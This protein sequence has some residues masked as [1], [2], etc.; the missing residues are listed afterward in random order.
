MK[1]SSLSRLL[2]IVLAVVL[3]GCSLQWRTGDAEITPEEVN[4]MLDEIQAASGDGGVGDALA[5][6][7]S[8]DAQ[9]FFA[10]APGPLGPVASILSIYRFNF[11]REGINHGDIV[12]ARVFFI[13]SY[14]DRGR[15][16]GLII[17]IQQIND[18]G[19]TYYGLTGRG[20]VSD[21]NM[22]VVLSNA[23]GPALTLRSYDVF[24]G[25]LNAVIQIKAY[26]YDSAGNEVYNGKFSTM[27]GFNN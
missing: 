8:P 24:R 11:L 9:I 16:F 20:D 3:S 13:D 1:P 23:N 5:L 22:R 26:D 2:F 14:D 15:V 27:I 12:G 10:D 21:T 7:D 19:Y 4:Q 25:E 17:G 6:R 18:D